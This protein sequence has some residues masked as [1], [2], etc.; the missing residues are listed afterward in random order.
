M[1][2]L[3]D[4]IAG[5]GSPTLPI[6]GL[7]GLT[8]D[9]DII[10]RQNG[11]PARATLGT[12]LSLVGSVL[13]VS[14]S[15]GAVDY[16]TAVSITS[17]SSTPLVGRLNLVSGT[18]G[19]YTVG[20]FPSAA[21][22]S[23]KVMHFKIA[24]YASANKLYTINSKVYWADESVILWSDGGSWIILDEKLNPFQ[25]RADVDSGTTYL[26]NNATATRLDLITVGYRSVVSMINTT[27]GQ[28]KIVIPRTGT[29]D[30]TPFIFWYSNHSANT[31][32]ENRVYKNGAAFDPT[33]SGSIFSG[34][35]GSILSTYPLALVAGDYLEMYGFYDA[36]TYT[37]RCLYSSPYSG[38][39]V[40]EVI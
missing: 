20:N 6:T 17:A 3:S 1:A 9:G 29:Y 32:V 37:T 24:P 7:T 13:S 39:M 33:V 11:M 2:N 26:F 27:A 12:G 10:V 14:V 38:L 22:N 36:G 21:S 35:G 28:G 25:A 40:T 8:T 15:G 16:T 18:T 19:D 31:K 34:V 23:G 5:G 30:I 4:V